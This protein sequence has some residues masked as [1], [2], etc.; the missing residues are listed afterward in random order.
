[1]LQKKFCRGT[2]AN[3]GRHMQWRST[4]LPN[5]WDTEIE[6]NVILNHGKPLMK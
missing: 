4:W 5:K 3:H 1:M 2:A 6:G